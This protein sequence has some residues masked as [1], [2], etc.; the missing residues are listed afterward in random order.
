MRQVRGCS[1][2]FGLSFAVPVRVQSPTQ[3]S[4]ALISGIGF[5]C[6]ACAIRTMAGTNDSNASFEV[7][8]LMILLLL[9]GLRPVQ[10]EQNRPL[11]KQGAWPLSIVI[12]S[13]GFLYC[14]Y[15]FYSMPLPEASPS[16]SPGVLSGIRKLARIVGQ[17]RFVWGVL[18]G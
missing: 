15:L 17:R 4:K 18:I 6:G 12:S 14:F 9:L 7:V 13:K 16:K 8:R 10:P 5:G 1:L 11:P 2:S 3:T